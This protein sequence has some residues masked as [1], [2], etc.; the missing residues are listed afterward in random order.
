MASKK[1]SRTT[2]RDPT[3]TSNPVRAGDAA[4]GEAAL[5]MDDYY[6][7][8]E[9]NHASSVHGRGVAD[10]LQVAATA[11]QPD[12]RVLTGIGIDLSGR[13]IAL[14]DGGSAE[15]GKN[16]NIPG[17][18]PT[19]A[20]VTAAGVTMPTGT[21]AAGSYY[22]TIQWWETF[23]QDAYNTYGIY[24]FNHTPWIRLV[25][26]AVFTDDGSRN[27]ETGQVF[28]WIVLECAGFQTAP[29]LL[30]GYAIS[31]ELLIGVILN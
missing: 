7:P 25:Q 12:I 1:L 31:K 24:R 13:H 16:A 27:G 6:R 30:T 19:L 23:D 9:Q 28:C 5:D 20:A 22:V 18:P 14:A 3:V 29:S 17:T 21:L 11:N 8:L 10:G 4:R 2:Y 15:I 26:V